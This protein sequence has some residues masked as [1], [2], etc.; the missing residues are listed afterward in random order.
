MRVFL[1]LLASKEELCST[2]LVVWLVGSLFR[3]LVGW[4]VGWLV[5]FVGKDYE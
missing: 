5:R 1:D 3:W 4:L 2:D